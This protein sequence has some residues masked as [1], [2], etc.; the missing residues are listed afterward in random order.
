MAAA[1]RFA[2]AISPRQN[3]AGRF[4]LRAKLGSSASFRFYWSSSS[5]PLLSSPLFGGSSCDSGADGI[6]IN[7]YAIT[8]DFLHFDDIIWQ[9]SAGKIAACGREKQN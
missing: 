9:K 5:S 8:Y 2:V 7:Q 1:S 4:F 3:E 6:K